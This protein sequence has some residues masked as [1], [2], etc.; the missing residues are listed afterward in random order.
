MSLHKHWS[1]RA[2]LRVLWAI[3]S[4]FI[5]E[6]LVFGFSVLPAAIF[7]EWHFHWKLPW[8][9]LHTMLLSMAFI[10]AYLLFAFF[11]CVLSAL[12]TKILRWR[13]PSNSE[14][15]IDDPGWPLLN[16]IRYEVSIHLVRS[17]AGIA[18]RATPLWSFYMRLN[19]AKLGHRVYVNSLWIT[20]H[21]LLEFG[22]DVVIGSEV[23][24]S[25]HTVEHGYVK[26]AGVHFGNRVTAGV[27][28]VVG[29]G[30][31]AGEGCHIGALSF[32]PKFSKLEAEKRYAGVPVQLIEKD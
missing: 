17:F 6:S 29:I 7:F 20:D 13:T 21:N 9:W 8:P 19:G 26:T 28:C 10:P 15:P 5:V 12:A 18:F 22:D 2:K 16:W 1:A 11:L 30:V 25:G 3:F 14:M 23:H 24:L 31:E 27:S 4:C 32:V